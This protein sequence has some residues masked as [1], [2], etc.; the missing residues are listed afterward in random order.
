MRNGVQGA[1]QGR[2]VDFSALDDEALERLKRTPSAALGSCR[3]KLRAGDAERLVS[4]CQSERVDAFVYIGG[5]V[6]RVTPIHAGE[7]RDAF[8]SPIWISHGG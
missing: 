1:L 4:L 8:H 7:C 2:L 5:F 3:Y 6:R